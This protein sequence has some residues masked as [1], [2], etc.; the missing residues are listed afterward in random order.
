MVFI[1][2]QR[3]SWKDFQDEAGENV[4]LVDLSQVVADARGIAICTVGDAKPYLSQKSS[5]ST[6][7]LALLTLEEIPPTERGVANV[8]DIRYPGLTVFREIGHR[9]EWQ[10]NEIS[11]AGVAAVIGPWIAR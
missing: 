3:S 5:I 6:D 11:P 10:G 7:A 1:T 2:S 8:S 9:C 4:A